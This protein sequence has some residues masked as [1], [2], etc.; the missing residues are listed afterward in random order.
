MSVERPLQNRVRAH[1]LVHGWSQE[2]LAS[3]A[4]VSRAGIS[5]IEQGRLVPSAATALN[6]ATVFGCR[7]E[8]IFSLEAAEA[9]Q[10]NWAWPP[11]HDPCRFWQATVAGK[12]LLYPVEPT[13]LGTAPHD[14]SLR[15]WRRARAKLHG[16]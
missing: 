13:S 6:L 7:V 1:R 2:E 15:A 4:G 10:P 12:R 8:D 5:A 16:S 11:P 3:R 14:G 9:N